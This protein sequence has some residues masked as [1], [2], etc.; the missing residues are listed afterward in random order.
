MYM[1]TYN[2]TRIY[3]WPIRSLLK[4]FVLFELV[5]RMAQMA[6][7]KDLAARVLRLECDFTERCVC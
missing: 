1:Y 7:L 3:S 2:N 6:L 4:G 5:L